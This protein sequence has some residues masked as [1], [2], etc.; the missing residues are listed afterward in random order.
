MEIKKQ[1]EL[2]FNKVAYYYDLIF[3][4][5]IIKMQT[6]IIK[7]AKIRNKSKILDVGCGTGNLLYLL[8]KY[9]NAELYGI[10]ISKEMLKIAKKKL[11]NSNL[12]LAQVENLKFSKNYFDYIFIVDAFHHFSDKEKVMKNFYRVLKR[13][14]KLII[15]DVNFGT[16]LN[17]IF[18]KLEPGNSGIYT[19]QEMKNIFKQYNFREIEQKKV[20]MF[21]TMTVGIK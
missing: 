9:T 6:R 12:K 21:T 19:K 11:R 2:F 13:K 10:D 16:F 1:N 14:G 5:W 17:N 8:E 18:Q 4:N 15:V 7:S 3:G 20:G